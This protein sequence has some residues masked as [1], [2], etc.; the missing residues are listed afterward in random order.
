MRQSNYRINRPNSLRED[1]Q[2]VIRLN[3]NVTGN[4]VDNIMSKWSPNLRA[5]KE[6][7]GGKVDDYKLMST[8]ILLENTNNYLNSRGSVP[9]VLNEDATQ[10]SN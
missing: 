10:P 4:R 5:I 6:A 8:A 3:E 7:F 2:S 9:N 1:L